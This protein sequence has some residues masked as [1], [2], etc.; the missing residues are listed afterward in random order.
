MNTRKRKCDLCEALVDESDGGV[1]RFDGEH[2]VCGECCRALD[3]AR[4]ERTR[5]TS[6][7]AG[8]DAGQRGA[9]TATTPPSKPA[10]EGG[11]T[12]PANRGVRLEDLPFGAANRLA[13]GAATPVAGKGA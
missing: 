8:A 2:D 1:I 12:A 5:Q 3:A 10:G 13:P 9:P 6:P 11:S 4:A 7:H